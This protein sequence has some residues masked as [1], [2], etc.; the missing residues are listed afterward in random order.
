M[1]IKWYQEVDDNNQD[2]I[3]EDENDNA[4]LISTQDSFKT[5]AVEDLSWGWVQLCCLHL[6]VVGVIYGINGMCCD[7]FL[8]HF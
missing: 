7:V 5:R 6:G 1:V 2:S 3:N 4:D 8:V